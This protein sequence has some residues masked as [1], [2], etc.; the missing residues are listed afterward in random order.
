VDTAVAH[1]S[2]AMGKPTWVMIP[3]IPDW[4]WG[5]HRQDTPW[6]PTMR[7]FRQSRPKDWAGV[8]ERMRRE[9]LGQVQPRSSGL[10][11]Y[12]SN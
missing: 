7:L 4:R 3:F 1:L 2:G 6:Y 12:S 9:L 11:N 8:V 10:F 5:M